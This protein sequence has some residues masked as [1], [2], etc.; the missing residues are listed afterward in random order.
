M[1][2]DFQLLE[3]YVREGSEE[4]FSQLVSRYLNLVYSSAL[5]QTCGNEELA[6]D[7]SQIVFTGLA[8]KA[9]SLSS[10]VVLGGWLYKRTQF[11]ASQALRTERR[12]LAREEKA[13]GMNIE[14]ESHESRWEDLSPLLDEAMNELDERDRDVLV[15]RFLEGRDLKEV[16][17][18]LGASEDA[19]RMRVS[20][21]LDKLRTFFKKR[22]LTVSTASLAAFLTAHSVSAAPAGLAATIASTALIIGKNSVTPFIK[23][24]TTLTHIKT[25]AALVIVGG[26]STLLIF[27]NTSMNRLHEQIQSQEKRLEELEQLKAENARLKSVAIDTNELARLQKAELEL[28]KMRNAMGVKVRN[29][30]STNSSSVVVTNQ[31]DVQVFKTTVQAR[32]G[33]DSLLAFGGWR[34]TSGK[35]NLCLLEPSD[36]KTE[37]GSIAYDW[38]VVAAS[39]AVLAEAGL[40][41]VKV[42]GS[43]DVAQVIIPAEKKAEL[44]AKLM[45]TSGVDCIWGKGSTFEGVTTAHSA[46]DTFMMGTASFLAGDVSN[47]TG[48]SS[49]TRISASNMPLIQLEGRSAPAISL[50]AKHADDGSSFDFTIHAEIQAH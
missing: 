36:S 16:G 9:S 37:K 45:N 6:K 22:G 50:Q 49:G 19:A 23:I 13:M 14:D 21:A 30:L 1:T 26:L 3:R 27:Q 39:D 7:I 25:A 12:R 44:L 46:G 48:I 29:S 32:I 10:R 20:R 4:A 24:M 5:R 31:A 11:V 40:D 41:S 15:L 18:R 33:K 42:D 8:Q 28:L 2:D 47:Q 34:S 43:D 38:Y 35:R 17:E